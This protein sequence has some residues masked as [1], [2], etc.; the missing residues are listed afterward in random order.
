MKARPLLLVHG[1]AG[2]K[3][4]KKES[5]D[6]IAESLAAGYT[7]LLNGG[8]SRDAVVAA[9]TVLENSGMFNAGLGGVLQLDEYNG[10]MHRLWKANT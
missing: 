8:P 6:V 3:P 5:L 2:Y 9:V 10:S 1:G 4:P 7:I